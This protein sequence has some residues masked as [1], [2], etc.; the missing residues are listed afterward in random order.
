MTRTKWDKIDRK[1][2]NKSKF[3]DWYTN[4]LIATCDKNNK[5]KCNC[6]K[7]T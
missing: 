3:K 2:M 1:V 6:C 7:T 4:E 5:I